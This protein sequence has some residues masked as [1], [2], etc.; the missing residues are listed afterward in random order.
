[1]AAWKSV[2]IPE[3]VI[4]RVDALLERDGTYTSRGELVK[5]AVLDYLDQAEARGAA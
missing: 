4:K 3:P 5:R 1:M 2:H